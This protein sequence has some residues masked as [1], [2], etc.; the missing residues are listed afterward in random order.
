[1]ELFEKDSAF[2]LAMRGF[3]QDYIL[4]KTGF[5]V[6]YHNSKIKTQTHHI[7]RMEYR[8]AF[9]LENYNKDYILNVIACYANGLS[10][11]DVLSKLGVH[12]DRTVQLKV[13][14]DMLGLFDEFKKADKSFR[15]LNMKNGAIVKYG[16]DNVFKLKEIQE[17][18]KQTRINKYGAPYTLCNKSSLCSSA[19]TTMDEHMKDET[20][21]KCV[22]EK[23][24]AT[25]MKHYGVEVSTQSKEI[26]AKVRQTSLERF[27]S[28]SYMQTDE[29]KKQASNYM[30][31]HGKEH[32]K[33]SRKTCL[34]KYGVDN[35]SKTE[36][37]RQAQ[38]KR[39]FQNGDKIY[40]KMRKTMEKRYGVSY[41]S[42]TDIFRQNMSKRVKQHYEEYKQKSIET[43]LKKYGVDFYAKTKK[44]RQTQSERMLD[45]EYNDHIIRKK[46]EN[47][48]LNT[49]SCEMK[50]YN[51]L[52][53]YFGENDVLTQHKD[54]RYPFNCDFYIK[55]RDMFIELNATWA[56]GGHWY[57]EQNACD[58]DTLKDWNSSPKRYYRRVEMNWTKSDVKK[59]NTAADNNLNYIVFWDCGLSDAILWFAMNCP[60]GQDWKKEY[61]WLPER[62]INTL[63]D[64]TVDTNSS[65]IDKIYTYELLL[66][67]KNPYL[68][69]Y[70]NIHSRLYSNQY[71]HLGKLPNE[72]SDI[73]IITGISTSGLSKLHYVL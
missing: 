31:K 39:M 18:A 54:V 56:H 58:I 21:R 61:S 65:N 69:K 32:A 20:F 10:K 66:W 43:C 13:L 42:Q 40:P 57:S 28:S 12:G 46:K 23:R 47:G 73:E 41:Y 68:K 34:E 45:K 64:I 35:Y 17:S 67:S 16:V 14:F 63:E 15:K 29:G 22:V 72:L 26:K 6:G 30:K 2:D 60:N 33:K 38:S 11:D 25:T 9:I 5:D 59:R 7:N 48:T 36:E 52:V 8:V 37:A 70:G 24:K 1:M 44:A 19:R 3:Q 53:D 4:N 27:G 71:K 55:S 49:S 50:L 62:P 51:M